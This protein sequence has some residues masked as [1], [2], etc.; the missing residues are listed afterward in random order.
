[1]DCISNHLTTEMCLALIG[2]R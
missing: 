1:M 2:Y